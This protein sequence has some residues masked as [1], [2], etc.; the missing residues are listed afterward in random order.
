M[1]TTFVSKDILAATAENLH[2]LNAALQAGTVAAAV[3]TTGVIPA[4]ADVVSF[5]TA[6][7][8]ASHATVFQEI[9]AHAAVAREQLATMLAVSSGSYAATED[10]NTALVG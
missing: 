1:P 4:A 2:N 3:P 5:L 10:A 6:A 7:Q 8:F 9:N